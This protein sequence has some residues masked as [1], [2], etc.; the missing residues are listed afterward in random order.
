MA[1]SGALSS[2][3]FGGT[4]VAAVGTASVSTSRPAQIITGIGD[5]SDT[6]IAGVMGGTASLDI[7]F[8]E[9]SAGHLTMTSNIGSASAAA[10]VVFTLATV[11]SNALTV[12]GNAFVTGYDITA[13]AGQV[14]R[15]TINLQFTGAI[16][17]A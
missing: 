12:S 13:T 6:F 10:A 11:S 16:T 8:D 14:V 1:I 15:A 7:F 4:T 9:A 5:T 3:S 17:V 2:F